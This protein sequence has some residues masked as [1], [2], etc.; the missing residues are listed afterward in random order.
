M[1]GGLV[2]RLA[3][4]D[5]LVEVGVGNRSDIA[6]ALAACGRTVTATDIHERPTPDGVRFVRDDVT[7][8]ESA[9]YRDADAVYALNC[10]PE[11]QRPTHDVARRVGVSFLFTTLGGDPAV[12][13]ATPTTLPDGRTLFDAADRPARSGRSGAAAGPTERG[14]SP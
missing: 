10:P 9:V 14:G 3:R 1:Q 12:V 11:L 7:D 8:P 4:H 2:D 5:H 6:R 13:P